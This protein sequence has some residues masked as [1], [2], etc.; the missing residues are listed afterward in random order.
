MGAG[1]GTPYPGGHPQGRAI[2]WACNRYSTRHL[3][4]SRVRPGSMG[5][6]AGPLSGAVDRG[7]DR[8]GTDRCGAGRGMFP[9]RVS[10]PV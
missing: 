2:G 4:H 3:G 9:L 6:P 7:R 10:A 8:T 5:G 1:W